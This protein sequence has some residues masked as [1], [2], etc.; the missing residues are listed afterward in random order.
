MRWATADVLLGLEAGQLEAVKF[1]RDLACFSTCAM[2]S[3]NEGNHGWPAGLCIIGPG[4]GSLSRWSLSVVHDAYDAR[5]SLHLQSHL[6]LA[7]RWT[8]FLEVHFGSISARDLG[9]LYVVF[10]RPVEWRSRRDLWGAWHRKP[11][12]STVTRLS[13]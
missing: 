1:L 5:R 8:G 10:R 7:A 2:R 4:I 9:L 11:V 12:P 13:R 3:T 6:A